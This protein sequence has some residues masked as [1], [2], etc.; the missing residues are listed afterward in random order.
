MKL[1]LADLKNRLK[2]EEKGYKLPEFD[3]ER[4]REKTRKEPIWIHFGAGN[5]FR[6]FP[7]VL[8]QTLL[9]GGYS[10]RGIIVCESYDEEIIE[11]AY[12][13]FDNLSVVVTL[14]ADGSVDKR[15]VASVAEAIPARGNMDRLVEIFTS[16]SLQMVSFTI[17]EKGYS[18]KNARGEYYPE[19]VDDLN[20]LSDQP[21]TLMAMVALL[22][23]KR[24]QAGRLPIA[25]VSMDNCSHN[26]T[27]LYEAVKA[28]V[29]AWVEKGFVDKGFRDYIEDPNFVS[30]PWSM[31]DKITPRPSEQ[32]K[33]LLEADGLEGA[34][35]VCTRKNTYI[36]SFVNAEEAQYLVI[37][38]VFPNSR[39]PLEK[40]GVIFT[41]RET[42][43]KV[44]KMKVCTCLNPLHTVLAIYGCLLGYKS[45]ADEMKDKHLKAFIEKVG[46]EEGLPVVVD[47][48]IIDP[49]EFIKE[50]IEKRFPNP[51]VPDTPQ[52][53]ATDTSQKI[54]VRFGE[55]LKAYIR[56]E[57][58]DISTLT[59]IP[60]FFAGWLRYL[61]GI[62]DEGN[63]FTPSPDP[64]LEPLQSY[65]KDIKL[66]D[67]GPF[68]ETLKPILSNENIFGVNLY[69]YG[70]ASKVEAMFA[71]LVAG[72][73]AVR[74]TLEKYINM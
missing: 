35:I 26:G 18:L 41:D 57:K 72:K 40:A 29:D 66:G 5:I 48:G 45:I 52:R 25:L 30:F 32:V 42:V 21:K 67:T 61:M 9:E 70:L 11:K 3:I 62:D 58:R 12:A 46:Y 50:V 22:C 60:L 53:I 39:P 51:F 74:K 27:R 20:S 68:T 31:I 15:V 63:P 23:Y 64:M 69:E 36:S 59:Y 13:P 56:T 6:A 4:V 8:Q 17:T 47:P 73:G 44:E 28:F 43:D 33:A 24:Y 19:V 16:P 54:P 2:W 49:Q 34:D 14:R 38:D 55:T 71:E 65:V 10:D 1:S 7:A 37:E